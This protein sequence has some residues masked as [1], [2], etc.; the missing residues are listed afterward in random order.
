MK[1][2]E[3]A[4]LTLPARLDG[5]AARSLADRLRE[6]QGKRLTIDASGV[7]SVGTLGLQVLVATSRQWRADGATLELSAMSDGLRATC[8]RFG[9][10]VA[11]IGARV[12]E[13]DLT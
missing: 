7:E 10:P 4:T 13:E 12:E 9:V 2:D 1:A 3:T 8:A 11:E 6:L 5:L